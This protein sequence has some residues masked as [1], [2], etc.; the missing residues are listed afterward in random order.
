MQ[1]GILLE[2]LVRGFVVN[3]LPHVTSSLEIAGIGEHLG[4]HD[5]HPRMGTG[6]FRALFERF[7][8]SKIVML[9]EILNKSEREVEAPFVRIVANAFSDERH[10]SLI[11]SGAA[12]RRLIEER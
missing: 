7:C 2:I 9:T 3:V 4:R 1:F 11:I 6:N 5:L 8:G 12:G 10:R